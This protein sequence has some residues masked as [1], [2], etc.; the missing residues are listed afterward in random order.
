MRVLLTVRRMEGGVVV[1]V[2]TY[3]I[4]EATGRILRFDSR[5][6]TKG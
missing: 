3:A 1:G 2:Q 5:H 6:E 4:G